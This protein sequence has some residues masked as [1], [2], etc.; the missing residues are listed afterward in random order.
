MCFSPF[1]YFDRWQLL[2]LSLE[3]YRQHGVDVQVYYVESAL[4][5]IV[6]VLKVVNEQQNQTKAFAKLSTRLHSNLNP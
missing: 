6:D 2:L 5:S 3:V 4:S 1:Y